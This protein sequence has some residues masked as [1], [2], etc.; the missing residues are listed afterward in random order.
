[1]LPEE[2]SSYVRWLIV[3]PLSAHTIRAYRSRVR[4]FVEYLNEKDATVLLARCPGS[5]YYQ[6]LL[7]NRIVQYKQFLKESLQL[8]ASTINNTLIAI[9]HFLAF[10]GAEKLGVQRESR[11]KSPFKVLNAEQEER[12]FRAID[13]CKSNRNKAIAILFYS[14]GLKLNECVALDLADVRLD[15]HSGALCIGMQAERK[16]NP[17][18]QPR[19]VLL[20]DHAQ[21]YLRNWIG[22]RRAKFGEAHSDS[23][24][25]VNQN[26]ARLTCAGIDYIVR[27]LGWSARLELSAQVLRHTCLTKLVTSTMDLSAVAQLGGYKNLK[28]SRRYAQL[29][30]T[31]QSA[32]IQSAIG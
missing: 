16:S 19:I 17:G 9:D 8:K 22:E 24:L 3:Q 28:T 29:S 31:S 21:D 25:F 11:S 15:M 4:H 10:L 27:K 23:A 6:E 32:F 18:K 1:L 14:V 5:D 30:L 26:G 20:T 13:V 7:A 12:F 2:Y